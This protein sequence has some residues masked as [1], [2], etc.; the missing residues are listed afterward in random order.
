M[1][2]G[3][4]GGDGVAL[5]RM[6]KIALAIAFVVTAAG[7]AAVVHAQSKPIKG[8]WTC[9]FTTAIGELPI[10]FN[11]AKD[12]KGTFTTPSGTHALSYRDKNGKVSAAFE[13]PQLAPDGGDITV[14]MRGAKSSDSAMAGNAT[15]VTD[16]V[17]SANTTGFTTVQVPFT[18]SR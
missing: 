9:T 14:V 8:K 10:E 17:D 5:A 7:T 4:G 16:T 2:M 6:R 11:F 12:G 13:A 15:F 18:C 3:K 1:W